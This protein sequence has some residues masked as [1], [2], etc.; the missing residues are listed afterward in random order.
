MVYSHR[1]ATLEPL[2]SIGLVCSIVM[3]CF[4]FITQHISEG[5]HKL[6]T[7]SIALGALYAAVCAIEVSLRLLYPGLFP[8]MAVVL[9]GTALWIWISC[10]SEFLSPFLGSVS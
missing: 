5:F 1:L 3:F 8:L 2:V 9:L 7:I 10:N 4:Y 6:A